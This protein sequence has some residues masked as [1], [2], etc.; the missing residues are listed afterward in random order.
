MPPSRHRHPSPSGPTTRPKNYIYNVDAIVPFSYG[1]AHCV[2]KFLAL[3]EMKTLVCY[4]VQ[5]LDMGLNGGLMIRA[6]FMRGCF[7]VVVKQRV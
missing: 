3:L 6:L 2:G 1:P 7:L 4:M 5:K